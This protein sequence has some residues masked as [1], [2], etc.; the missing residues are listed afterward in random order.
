MIYKYL[1]IITH[2]G[3]TNP[4]RLIDYLMTKSLYI[5]FRVEVQGRLMVARNLITQYNTKHRKTQLFDLHKEGS[6]TVEKKQNMIIARGAKLDRGNT[7][8]TNFSAMTKAGTK[9]EEVERIVQIVN[10]LGNDRL[11]R[12]RVQ[13]FVSGNSMLNHIPELKKLKDVFEELDA[14]M[15]GFINLAWYYAPE[16]RLE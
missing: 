11:I 12:E 5:G 14:V 9:R 10:V 4:M 16:A 3:K 7:G 6:I 2:K 15:P 1:I 8:M 13:T